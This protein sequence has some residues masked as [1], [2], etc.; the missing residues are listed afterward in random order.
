MRYY[1]SDQ[2]QNMTFRVS[3]PSF[4]YMTKISIL[5]LTLI[6]FF[7]PSHAL[8]QNKNSARVKSIDAYCKKVDSFIKHSKSPQLV[9]ADISDPEE[10][11]QKWKKFDSEK[12]LEK[13]RETAETY[14]IAFNW[15][16]NG[17]VAVSNFT[18]FSQSGDWAKYVYHYFR[19][20]GSL[21]RA[22]SEL[23]TFYGD[24]IVIRSSYFDRNGKLIHQSVKYLDLVK[25]RPKK[26]TSDFLADNSNEVDY[27][28]KTSKLPFAHLL[29][30]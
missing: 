23:R 3:G 1:K 6:I 26:P 16:K 15:Q 22:E 10:A 28:K 17:N 21:A 19:E 20:D 25:K 8:S 14:T 29:K 2:R 7:Y 18:L 24:Y 11:K 27:F 12:A 4:N 30:K 5:V 9:F 13:F